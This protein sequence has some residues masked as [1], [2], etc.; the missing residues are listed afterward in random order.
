MTGAE[1]ERS[2]Q[3]RVRAE[4][5]CQVVA[6]RGGLDLDTAAYFSGEL[7]AVCRGADPP[8]LIVDLSGLDFCDSSGLN[9]LVQVWRRVD[10]AGG[11]LAL[12][13]V[14]GSCERMLRRTGLLGRVFAVF[15]SQA[16]AKQA[17]AGR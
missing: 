1:A 17:L 2:L 13:G 6:V 16:Q 8:L 9:A 10:G 7:A 5:P 15:S 11:A 3:V 12:V 14:S 4:P